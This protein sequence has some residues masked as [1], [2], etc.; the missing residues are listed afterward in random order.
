[1]N[2]IIQTDRLI[3]RH[4]DMERDFAGFCEAMSDAE[5]M[6]FIGGAPLCRAGTWR[7]MAMLV[8]HMAIRGYGFMSAI[9]KETDQWV[10]RVGPWFPEG[11]PEPEI[12]WMIHP[13]FTRR[14]FAREAAAACVEYAFGT[15]GWDRV[16]HVIGEQNIGSIKTAESIGSKRSYPVTHLP[17]FGKTNCW[18]YEQSRQ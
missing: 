10:G 4:I 12:G 15:L 6:R 2:P 13:G 16:M 8:G 17:P 14:G 7:S 5:T 3:L 18:V 9:E 11:W 1:M